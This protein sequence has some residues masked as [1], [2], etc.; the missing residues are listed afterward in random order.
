MAGCCQDGNEPSGFVKCEEFFWLGEELLASE[1]GP[2]SVK[3]SLPSQLC[4]IYF[5]RT[6]VNCRISS[7]NPGIQLHQNSWR[8]LSDTRNNFTYSIFIVYCIWCV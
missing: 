5:S 1:E 6:E 4:Q 3:P 8:I 7:V 2:C